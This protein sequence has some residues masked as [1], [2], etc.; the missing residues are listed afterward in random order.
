VR[1]YY[2]L[3]RRVALKRRQLVRRNIGRPN[4]KALP[5]FIVE[6]AAWLADR[7]TR[8]G[9]AGEPAPLKVGTAAAKQRISAA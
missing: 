4:F 9:L 7:Q 5:S 6:L 3:V 8:G 1:A 2:Y